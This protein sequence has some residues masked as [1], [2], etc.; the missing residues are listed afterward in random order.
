MNVEESE[1]IIDLGCATITNGSDDI[2]D[3]QAAAEACVGACTN[4]MFYGI[5]EG[6]ADFDDTMVASSDNDF[7]RIKE[8]NADSYLGKHH[9]FAGIEDGGADLE[10]HSVDV[11]E[12]NA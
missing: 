4:D 12:F 3:V 6:N 5:E 11:G 10:D 7:L 1:T 8:G 9:I 2:A